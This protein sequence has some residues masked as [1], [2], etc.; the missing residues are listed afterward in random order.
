MLPERIALCGFMGAGKT[1]AGEALADELGYR[2]IDLDEEIVR[3]EG[4]T[5]AAIFAESG[6]AYFREVEAALG[7][8]LL[9]ESEIVLSLGGG[10]VT[11][12][13][14]MATVRAHACLIYLR[15]EPD[16]LW[17]RITQKKGRPLVDGINTYEEFL[18]MHN[19]RMEIRRPLY[20]SADIV[21]E[22]TAAPVAETVAA[23]IARLQEL[24]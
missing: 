19:E 5:I 13:R 23:V 3:Q 15:A 16:I 11:S 7:C 4:Q 20:E 24:A 1:K 14:I 10:A 17:E 9:S 12:Q 21:V 6:E 2:F 22:S 18:K 8:N